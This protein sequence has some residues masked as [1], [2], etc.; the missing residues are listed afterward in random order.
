MLQK[1]ALELLRSVSP[2]G[3]P[4]ENHCIRLAEFALAIGLKEQLEPDED[5]VRAACFLHDIGLCVDYDTERNYLKRGL[6]FFQAQSAEWRLDAEQ[7]KMLDDA[8]LYNHSLVKIPGIDP[9][10]DLVRRAVSVE[11]S[12]GLVTQGLD[13]KF[14]RSVFV[15]IPRYGFNQVL[16]S[17]FRIAAIDDGPAT[18]LRIFFPKS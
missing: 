16:L 12:H 11:H 15:K 17:F 1:R 14:C 18:L 10:A 5:L 4:L 13:R 6:S 8:L 3:E 9:Q 7:R 2:Y